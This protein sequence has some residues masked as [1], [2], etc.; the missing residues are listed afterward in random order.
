MLNKIVIFSPQLIVLFKRLGI[1]LL[2]FQ[3]TRVIFLIANWANFAHISVGDFFAS[4]WFDC[5]TIS[6]LG[7]P[8]ICFS[9]IPF[10]FRNSKF[11]QGF[12]NILFHFLNIFFIALN[13]I[14]VVYFSFT[15]KRSTVDLLT[16]VGGGD[17][18][19]Q[20]IGS[21]FRDFWLLLV[22]LLMLIILSVWL[23]KKIK[24][25]KIKSTFTKDFIV[26]FI[27]L[28]FFI[29]IARGGLRLKPISP[30]DAST[31]TRIENTALIL[32]TPFTMIKSFNQ[33]FLEEKNYFELSTEKNYFDP[34]QKSNPQ[35]LFK[36]KPNVVVIILES[37]GNEWIGAAGAKKSFTPFLDS[38]TNESLYF[39]NG[40]ANGKKSI[41]ALPCIVSSIPSLVDNPY[42]SSRYGTNKINSLASLLSKNGYETAFFHGATNGSMRFD[43]FAAQ[44]G[45][46]HYFGRK[47]YNNDEHFDKTWGI[48]DE[49]FNPW[50]AKK[51]SEFKKPF[52]ASLFTLSSHHPY[53]IPKYLKGKLRKG[54]QQICE[55][56]HYGDYSLAKF[57]KEAQKQSW[58]ENTLFVI[59][60]DHTSSTNSEI[61]NQRTE[62]YKIPILFFSPNKIIKAKKETEVFQQMDILPTLLDLLNIEISFYAYGR[63][64]YNNSRP[65]E[66]ITYIE[67]TYHYF[68][69][70]HMMTFSNDQVRNY[71]NIENVQEN[72]T[73]SLPFYKKEIKKQENRLKA[74]I[75]RYNRDLIMN[76]MYIK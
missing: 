20:Q 37:F 45:F 65:N 3:L 51:L 55:S 56:I 21:F 43:G 53:F 8:Y 62:M 76:Q 73:D 49:Y 46:E 24:F 32:N 66:A 35:H 19:S 61:Y 7:F 75:Q 58:Y 4:I 30:I 14:D 71:Y 16:V 34:I 50:T 52:F 15:Q 28:V 2:C 29:L 60:A 54:P 31:F 13:L 18:F 6:L 42:I 22:F 47:E 27:S 5:I 68:S 74:I 12:L 44:A 26:F 10:S 40:I 38:L 72:N 67:G 63:S 25:N 36:E 23:N 1:I 64:Y 9:L 59:C 11:Y 41:E 69:P 33:E 48:L 57:F 70:K 39:V 17:D